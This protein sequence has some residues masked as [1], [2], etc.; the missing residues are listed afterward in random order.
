M[1]G[2]RAETEILLVGNWGSVFGFLGDFFN[3]LAQGG[4]V[5]FLF[6]GTRDVG[7]DLLEG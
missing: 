5:E 1:T 3:E 7:E 4:L 6:D 2:I